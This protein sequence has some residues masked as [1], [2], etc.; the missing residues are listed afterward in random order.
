MISSFDG[1]LTHGLLEKQVFSF[2]LN[3]FILDSSLV[4]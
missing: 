3:Y 4:R 1:G 2:H